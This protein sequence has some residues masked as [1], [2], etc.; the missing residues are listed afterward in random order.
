MA[1]SQQDRQLMQQMKAEYDT[2]TP[3]KQAM[4]RQYAQGQYDQSQTTPPV[5]PT[6]RPDGSGDLGQ[7]TMA[8]LSGA[9]QAAPSIMLTGKPG[10]ALKANPFDELASYEMKK[11]KV[12]EAQDAAEDREIERQAQA[13][14]RKEYYSNKPVVVDGQ[15]IDMT[16]AP[17]KKI[18]EVT[19]GDDG[20]FKRENVDNP[21]YAPWFEQKKAD[22][23]GE[24]KVKAGQAKKSGELQRV[25]SSIEEGVKYYAGGLDEKGLGSP[26]RK[27]FGKLA[28]SSKSPVAGGDWGEKYV[29]TGQYHGQLAEMVLGIQ[30]IITNQ[31]RALSSVIQMIRETFAAGGEGPELAAGKFEQTLLNQYKIVTILQRMGYTVESEEDAENILTAWGDEEN[32]EWND[33]SGKEE[34]IAFAEKAVAAIKGGIGTL[35]D[36]ERALYEKE[37]DRILEPLYSRSEKREDD[38][39]FQVGD[40]KVRVKK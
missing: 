24:A 1:I 35:T 9:M 3:D 17:P 18:T 40:F 28:T 39:T 7:A 19:M 21:A 32:E 16:D 33:G 13:D 12:K 4:L 8:G 25:F 36:E 34:S 2:M 6:E 11:L 14:M 37:R 30:P 15:E 5:Q 22:I 31:N 23:K 27:I 26:M 38:F 20:K 29:N 10:P